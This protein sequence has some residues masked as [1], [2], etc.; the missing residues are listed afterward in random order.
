M[1]GSMLRKIEAVVPRFSKLHSTLTELLSERCLISA[2]TTASISSS[3]PFADR[4]TAH[5]RAPLCYLAKSRSNGRNAFGTSVRTT[6]I[7]MNYEILTTN[8]P[9]AALFHESTRLSVPLRCNVHLK[10]MILWACG[11]RVPGCA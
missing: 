4:N 10:Y 2:R 7:H 9:N 8:H 3:P 6:A 5:H 11:S 1:N